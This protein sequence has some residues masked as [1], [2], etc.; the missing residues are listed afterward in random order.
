MKDLTGVCK[1]C[2]QLFAVEGGETMTQE[3]KDSQATLQCNCDEAKKKQALERSRGEAVTNAEILFNED[4][5]EIT[6]LMEA[7]SRMMADDKLE[8]I[9]ITSSGLVSGSL[10]RKG[11]KFKVERTDKKKLSME[12]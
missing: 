12:T 6:K 8:K 10:V 5:P 2:G 11:N 7:A 3:E 1:Y 4:Y 9:S